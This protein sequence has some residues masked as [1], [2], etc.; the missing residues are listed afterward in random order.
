MMEGYT[1]W[2][3]LQIVLGGLAVF[4]FCW[5]L[6]LLLVGVADENDEGEV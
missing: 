5:L 2:E 6:Y 3:S 1:L 4:A